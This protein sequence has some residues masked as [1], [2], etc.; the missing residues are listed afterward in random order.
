MVSAISIIMVHLTS[1]TV[2]GMKNIQETLLCLFRCMVNSLFSKCVCDSLSR[3]L[4]AIYNCNFSDL[5]F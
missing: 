4:L 2:S 3:V 1:F 5:K